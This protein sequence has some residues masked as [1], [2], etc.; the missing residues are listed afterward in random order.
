MKK[1]HIITYGCQMNK[2]DSER[3]VTLLE[4][5]GYKKAPNLS[6]A[7]LI[8]V[9]MC[10]VRQTAV[11]RVLGQSRKFAKLKK[12]NPEFKTLL[13]GCVLKKDFKRF[14]EYFDFILP[15]KTLKKWSE[16]LE[17][18]N[19]FFLPDQRELNFNKNF[20]AN[21]FQVSPQGKD[22]FLAFIPISAGCNNFCAYCVVP[23]TRGPLICRS[24]Q[25][26]INEVKQAV[27]NGAKELW[28]LGQNVNDYNSPT[29]SVINFPKL[30][31]QVNDIEGNFWIRFTSSHPKDFSDQLIDTMVNCKKVTEY[32]NLPVQSGDNKVLQRMNRPYTIE[33]YKKL[34][35]KIRK[36]IPEI[37][38]STDIIVG[39]PGETEKQFQNTVKLFEEIQYDMA[40]VAKYSPRAQTAAFKIEDNISLQEKEKRYKILTKALKKTALEKNQRYVGKEGE[41]LVMEN[42]TCKKKKAY[43][44]KTRSYKTVKFQISASKTRDLVGQF[45]RVKIIDASPF[46]LKG[47]LA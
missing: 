45:V 31:K 12:L 1:Y 38:L 5:T 2:S 6:E 11:D 8:V 25:E 46:G 19:Y 35:K 44:G 9:N 15:I 3:I 28:L 17:K 20:D 30:L 42:I 47:V 7:D 43:I 23:F 24:H 21:Y 22:N 40:Y 4:E 10:S 29:D 16:I 14:K 18:E 27:K 26:I 32:L 33:Q 36:K 39:F 41:V 13:T 34:V 37:C